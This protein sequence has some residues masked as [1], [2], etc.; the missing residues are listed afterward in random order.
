MRRF[1]INKFLKFNS[2]QKKIKIELLLAFGVKKTIDIMCC[3]IPNNLDDKKTLNI[4]NKNKKIY[5]VL[6]KVDKKETNKIYYGNLQVEN[7][8]FIFKKNDH[9]ELIV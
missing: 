4:L 8:G 3:D 5:F 7:N 2:N 9:I 1:L 6:N